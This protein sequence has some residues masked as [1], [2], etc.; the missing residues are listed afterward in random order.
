MSGTEHTP[1]QLARRN[2]VMLAV[3]MLG[4]FAAVRIH[5]AIAPDADFNVGSYNVHHLFTGLVLITLGG[6]PLAVLRGSSR[7]MDAAL[8]AFGVGLGLALD[9]CVYLIVTDGSNA[10]YLLPISFWGGLIAV[11]LTIGYAV[12]LGKLTQG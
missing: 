1:R 2:A 4:S 11:G 12:G 3:A 6:I 10:S 9:E 5:L 7:R 8:V